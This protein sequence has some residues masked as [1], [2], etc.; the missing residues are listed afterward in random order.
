MSRNFEK[1][2]EFIINSDEKNAQKLFHQIVVNKSR[3]IYESFDNIEN[4]LD[5]VE[6]EEVHPDMLEAEP[7]EDEFMDDSE[8]E[9]VDDT[10]DEFAVDTE[11]EFAT[12]DFESEEVEG[13]V[14]AIEDRV[15]ELEDSA[16]ELES[17]LADLKAQ[18]E[19]IMSDEE[20]EDEEL[21]VDDE[22]EAD[23]EEMEEPEVDDELEADDEEMEEPEAEEDDDEEDEELDERF[24]REYTEKIGEPYKSGKGIA[25]TKEE[26]VNSKSVIAK[27]NDMG[28]TSKNLVQGGDAKG[29]PA[30]TTKPMSSEKF[31]NAQGGA[32]SKLSPAPKATNKEIEG[33]NKKGVFEAKKV[34]KPLTKPAVKPSKKKK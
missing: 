17:S 6:H 31:R 14:P 24:I 33:T 10:E 32:G 16:E 27:K 3:K 28:G 30:P 21:E 19:K 15:V 4:T 9:F 5:E 2:I 1:L 8:D 20:G 23:D 18:F 25:S 7:E 34:N 26:G 22:L 11:D 29:R 12:D 13:E